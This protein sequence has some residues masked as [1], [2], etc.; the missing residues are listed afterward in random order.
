MERIKEKLLNALFHFVVL[1]VAVS[2][3]GF[4]GMGGYL[5]GS[6]QTAKEYDVLFKEF[7][8]N[9]ATQQVFYFCGYKVVPKEKV[10]IVKV[11][12]Q[13][14][15]ELAEAREAALRTAINHEF[16]KRYDDAGQISIQN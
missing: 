9:V 4:A 15:A 13:E 5:F 14:R 1:S 11:K 2:I 7:K 6:V 16:S 12:A 8:D 10:V 3:L